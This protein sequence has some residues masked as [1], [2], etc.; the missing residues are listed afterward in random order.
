[1]SPDWKVNSS[2]F[3][4]AQL[5]CRL[6]E[7]V[8]ERIQTF[9]VNEVNSPKAENMHFK[10]LGNIMKIKTILLASTITFLGFSAANAADAI[11]YQE[12]TPAI[13]APSFTWNGAYIG[14]Q[15]GYGW[16]KSHY[17]S[18]LNSGELK[19]NGF[20]GGIYAGYNFALENNFVLGADIDVTY[21]DLKKHNANQSEE[22]ETELRWSGAARVRAGYA[23]DRFLPYIAGGVAFGQVQNK[24]SITGINRT[25]SDKETVTG[26]TLGAGVDYAV[27]DNVIVRFEYRYTDFGRKDFDFGGS[28][29]VPNKFKTNDIRLGVAY[30]F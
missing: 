9:A 25:Y 19:P 10:G 18:L 15:I 2:T 3:A 12:P 14:G 30:K 24:Y 6:S 11:Q 7:P 16:G 29:G 28:D 13:A 27:T 26:W 4:K 20:L 21:N 1:M 22:F 5:A 23:V 17:T 8:A